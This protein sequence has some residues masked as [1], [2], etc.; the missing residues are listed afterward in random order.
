MEHIE[1]ALAHFE[2]ILQEQFKR[3]ETM[4]K[5]KKDFSAMEKVTIGV[6]GGDGIGPIITDQAA[7]ILA[8]LLKDEIAAGK[9]VIKNIEGLTIENRLEKNQA[10]A[11]EVKRQRK[12]FKPE[13]FSEKV[14][15]LKNKIMPKYNIEQM[16]LTLEEM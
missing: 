15:H 1:K 4:N 8:H 2:A 14:E 3:L 9:I 12:E 10:V 16:C 7:R 13:H 6:C 11:V 5:P